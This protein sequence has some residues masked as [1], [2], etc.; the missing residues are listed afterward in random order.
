MN[1]CLHRRLRTCLSVLAVMALLW[2]QLV[3]A[4]HPITSLTATAS[5]EA[6]APGPVDQGCDH[7][8]SDDAQTLCSHHCSQDDQSSE[9]PR[10]PPV[11][12]A[13]PAVA[14]GIASV[15]A[16]EASLVRC[17]ELSPAVSWHRP[18]PHPANLLLI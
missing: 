3:L 2:S 16:L 10:V 1:R 5:G 4:G 11:P 8:A 17:I 6:I 12:V 13:M 14:L 9:V 18:T 7:L 15:V